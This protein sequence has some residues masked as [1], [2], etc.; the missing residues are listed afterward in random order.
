MALCVIY[1]ILYVPPYSGGLILCPPLVPLIS[2]AESVKL[3][4][5]LKEGIA[6]LE[7]AK[8]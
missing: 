8:H 2:M 5:E 1:R 4:Y 7:L 6:L 3:V